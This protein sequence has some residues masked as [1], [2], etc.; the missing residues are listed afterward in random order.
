MN[1]YPGKDIIITY[2]F[3]TEKEILMTCDVDIVIIGAGVVGLAIASQVARENREVFI[4]EKN[5]G[6]GR[7]S[8]SRNSGTI[9]TSI[10]S[11]RGSF[12]ARLCLEGCSLIYEICRKYGIDYRQTGKM[13]VAGDDFEAEALET[14][15]QRRDEGVNMQRLSNREMKNLEPEVKGLDAVLLPEAG[16]VDAYGLMWCLLGLARIQ[17]A[18]LIC[19]SELTGIEKTSEG[20]RITVRGSDG[21][22]NLQTR[23]IINCAGLHSDKVAGM[24]GIDTL[25]EG[26]QLHYFKGEYYSISSD[27]GKSVNRRLV[28]PMLRPGGLVG[29]HTVL[30][31]DGHVRFGPD[32]YP[33]DEI[34]YSINDSRKSIFLDGAQRLFSFIVAEDIDPESSGI[35]PRLYAKNKPFRSFIIRHEQDKGLPGLINLVGI[36]SPGLTSSPAI[37]RYVGQLVDEI[38][39]N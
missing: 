28:Y 24:A 20:Y 16:V 15:Y 38:L 27:K 14:L 8:S 39:K 33:V 26:Y 35:M 36:E 10:L 17:G 9:H 2:H 18:Q 22:S 25:K 4:L 34:E 13:L 11:P 32:F 23:I 21:V 29:I 5:D 12:N 1:H 19:N 3:N 7:E 30:D 37:G 31:F 6:F